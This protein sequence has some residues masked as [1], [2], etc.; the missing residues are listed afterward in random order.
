[1]VTKCLGLDTRIIMKLT[2][3]LIIAEGREVEDHTTEHNDCDYDIPDDSEE[4]EG[5]EITEPRDQWLSTR[6]FPVGTRLRWN[7]DPEYGYEYRLAIVTKYGILQVKW[8]YPGSTPGVNVEDSKKT[9]FD[10][11]AD[12]NASLPKNGDVTVIPYK[13]SIQKKIDSI[14]SNLSDP[15]KIKHLM[16]I[17]KVKHHYSKGVS[18]ADLVNKY[19]SDM[20]SMHARLKAHTLAEDMR[21]SMSRHRMTR[22]L[23]IY[24][25]RFKNYM[26]YANI[27]NDEE[28]VRSGPSY[29]YTTS[30]S[31]LLASVRGKQELIMFYEGKIA[32]G[33]NSF[34]A[35]T[36]ENAG[37]DMVNGKP[38]L[39][40]YYMKK[41]INI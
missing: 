20:E 25:T 14:P 21:D 29:V 27:L 1:M 35:T 17:F 15:E 37:I 6:P 2:D 3:W 28:Y 41:M 9:F 32:V 22:L 12:W 13:N 26:S 5:Q 8:V 10:T 19:R 16:N 7:C 24:V 38:V 39:S 34:L 4:E 23:K 40:A 18:P 33:N 31:T 11:P 30:K 36:F